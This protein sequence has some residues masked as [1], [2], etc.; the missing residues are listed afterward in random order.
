MIGLG[1]EDRVLKIGELRTRLTKTRG[2][3]ADVDGSLVVHRYTVPS[4]QRVIKRQEHVLLR[5]GLGDDPED[6]ARRLPRER[7]PG[8]RRF[9]RRSRRDGRPHRT[10]AGRD[11]ELRCARRLAAERGE[12]AAWQVS[13][14]AQATWGSDTDFGVGGRAILD[15]GMARDG[16]AFDGPA[17]PA[18]VLDRLATNKLIL[19][20]E[21]HW[22]REHR[23]LMAELVRQ[24]HGRGFRQILVDARCYLSCHRWT[25]PLT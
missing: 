9:R 8:G 3:R 1:W 17:I 5:P 20:G 13:V 16:V 14:A 7:E 19:V 6:L 11:R 22:L 21:T 10:R 25:A 2:R 23:V 24:L 15:L 12:C 4:E 18:T